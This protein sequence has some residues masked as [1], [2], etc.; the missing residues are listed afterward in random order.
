MKL[1]AVLALVAGVLCALLGVAHCRDGPATSTTAKPS[2]RH[3]IGTGINRFL[4]GAA[5][6][7]AVQQGFAGARGS[8]NHHSSLPNIKKP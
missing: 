8:K 5:V 3:K 2:W 1:A 6:V 4:Q 7:G